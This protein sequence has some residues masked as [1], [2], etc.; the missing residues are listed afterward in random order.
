VWKGKFD[1]YGSPRLVKLH[2]F[3]RVLQPIEKASATQERHEGR[4]GQSGVSDQSA[5]RA[6]VY[7]SMERNGQVG[8]PSF[9]H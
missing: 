9:A 4:S 2:S 5:E 7:L 1:E 6:G 3:T 8:G